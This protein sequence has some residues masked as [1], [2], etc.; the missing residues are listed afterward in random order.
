MHLAQ[1]NV[2]R[3]TFDHDSPAAHRFVAA[4]SEVNALAEASPGFVWRY[5]AAGGG[6]VSFA[7]A[8]GDPRLVLNLSVWQTYE[9]LHDFT[10]RTVHRGLLRHRAIWFD[11]VPG[12][13]TALWWVPV[14]EEPTPEHA[15]VRLQYL[16]RY[17]PSPRAFGVLR[18]FDESGR[19]VRR[20]VL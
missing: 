18:R 2:S 11:Q 14:G 20:R 12:P 9:Q 10:Y 17:G 15:L 5:R 1:V 3:L 16:R 8:I 4:V 19:P 6:H 7:D 13:S